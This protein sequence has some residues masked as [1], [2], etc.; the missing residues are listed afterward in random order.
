MQMEMVA[1]AAAS[2]RLPCTCKGAASTTSGAHNQSS[3]RDFTR[4]KFNPSVAASKSDLCQRWCCISLSVSHCVL[5]P[6]YLTVC[7]PRCASLPLYLTVCVPRCALLPLYLT[8][9]VPDCLCISGAAPHASLSAARL[10]TRRVLCAV[11]NF[12]LSPRNGLFKLSANGSH[13]IAG[14]GSR[15]ATSVARYALVGQLVGKVILDRHTVP[16]KLSNS[17][18]RSMQGEGPPGESTNT[19]CSHPLG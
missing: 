13:T 19:L 8:R 9:C 16:V 4:S 10:F 1:T 7:V 14:N 17:C 3:C 15:K 2:E 6:L 11:L 5:L 12:L 18:Y